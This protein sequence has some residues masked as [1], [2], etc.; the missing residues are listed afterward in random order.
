[1]G[2]I[3]NGLAEAVC[4]R[5]GTTAWGRVPGEAV[6]DAIGVKDSVRYTRPRQ[7]KLSGSGAC[8]KL[9]TSYTSRVGR[10]APRRRSP[11]YGPWFTIGD[12]F[13]KR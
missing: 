10:Q 1:M 8:E 9:Q 2:I 11:P 12:E 3:V 5:R 4:H 13:A 7:K 6:L